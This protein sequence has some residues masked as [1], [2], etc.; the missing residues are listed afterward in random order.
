MGKIRFFSKSNTEK[1]KKDAS[2]NNVTNSEV[3]N[4]GIIEEMTGTE[5]E[6]SDSPKSDENNDTPKSDEN[7]DALKSD[8]NN[9]IPKSD[10]NNETQKS[11]EKVELEESIEAGAEKT[12]EELAVL[13]KQLAEFKDK[14][15][16]QAAEYDN[17]RKRTLREKT[18]LIQTAG[19]SLLKDILPVVDDF[20]RGLEQAS[21]A[22]DMEAVKKGMDFI[23][24]KLKDFLTNNGVKEINAMNEPFDTDWHEAVV[25]I[26]A[27]SD[28]MKGMIVDVIQKGY[29]LNNK[30]I[31]YPKVVVGE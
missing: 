29:M 4:E 28:D 16:R 19:E 8:E 23:Y 24:S 10:E 25:N 9:D 13:Q 22:D 5:S 3:G 11:D 18:E 17:Y 30:V 6:I 14:Y 12:N 7:I 26:P 15:L 21:K 31:R 1:P 2:G 20:E 27:P